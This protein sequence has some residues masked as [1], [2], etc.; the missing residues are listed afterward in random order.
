V[1]AAGFGVDLQLEIHCLFD[2][3]LPNRARAA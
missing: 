1:K 2:R 3:L